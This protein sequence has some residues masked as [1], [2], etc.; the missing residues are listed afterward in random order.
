[1]T[2][3]KQILVE[4]ESIKLELNRLFR[5]WELIPGC[6]LDEFD[7]LSNQLLSHLW[8]G[9]DQTKIFNIIR[10]ELITRY[11]LSTSDEEAQQ[12]TDEAY[13]LWETRNP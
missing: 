4:F 11:G 3:N 7:H 5:D 10:S 8:E 12:I 9:A 13:E 6:P 1:M 2:K